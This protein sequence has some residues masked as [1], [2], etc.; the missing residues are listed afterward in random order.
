MIE[1]P[2]LLWQLPE[3][4]HDADFVSIGSNDL[5]QFLFAAD[6]GTPALAN[7]YDMLSP[8]VLDVIEAIATAAAGARGRALDLRRARVAAAR[9]DGV[10][11]LGHHRRCRC[12]RRACCG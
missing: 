10:R 2:A 9:G 1:V 6:R 5:M 3:L 8:P 11:R 4:M 12:R 7:R